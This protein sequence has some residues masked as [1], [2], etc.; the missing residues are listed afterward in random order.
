MEVKA[1]QKCLA[2][3]LVIAIAKVVNDSNYKV[4]RQ[5]RKIQPVV[6]TLLQATGID[7]STGADIPELVRFQEYVREYKIVV[8]HDI[9]C[10]ECNRHFGSRKFFA[11]DKQSTAAKKLLYARKRCCATCGWL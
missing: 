7:L 10:E 4:Y 8:Y 9:S 1:E 5:G 2:H 3:A 11:N 6:Q